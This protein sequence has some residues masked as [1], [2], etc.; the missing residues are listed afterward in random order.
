[1]RFF[2]GSLPSAFICLD[3]KFFGVV[4]VM[5]GSVVI[6]SLPPLV[7]L[8]TCKVHI[9]YRPGFPGQVSSAVFASYVVSQFL[10]LLGYTA[11]IPN[12]LKK[13]HNF[14]R[15]STSGFFLCECILGARWGNSNKFQIVLIL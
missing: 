8:F 1:V 9:V 2:F 7:R 12:L 15:F 14:A 5:G 10:G 4:A 11:A 6:L 13:F 3:A